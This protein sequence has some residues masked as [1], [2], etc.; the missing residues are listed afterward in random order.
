MVAIETALSALGLKKA[1]LLAGMLG[2]LI[3]G[4]VLPGPLAVLEA[5]WL[6]SVT[7]AVAGSVLAGFG[8]E[9][10]LLALDKPD[11]YLQGVALAIGLVGL[12]FVFKVAKAWNDF[13]LSTAL[14]KLVDK[15]MGRIQ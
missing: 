6:R 3:S 14:G 15:L 8:A 4:A 5:W 10:V 7:G 1:V 2:G 9:P 12:S 13:D 11:T